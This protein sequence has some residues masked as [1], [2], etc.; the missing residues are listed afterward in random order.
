MRLLACAI[1]L[2]GVALAHFLSRAGRL[3]STPG[4]VMG[5]LVGTVMLL[6]LCLCL[7]SARASL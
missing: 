3:P 2:F 6:G 7:G 1:A 5:L 4:E